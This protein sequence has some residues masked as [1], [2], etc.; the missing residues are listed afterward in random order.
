[1]NKKTKTAALSTLGCRVNQYESDAIADG[2]TGRGF[3]IVPFGTPADVTIL[4]T[5]TV[6]GESDRKSRQLIR[7]AVAA[8]PGCPVIVT[9][10]Y[11]ETGKDDVLRIDGVTYIKGNAKKS[12]IPGIAERLVSEALSFIDTD[13]VSRAAETIVDVEDI[14]ASTYDRMTLTRASRARS[15]MKIEDGCDNRCAY[16][17]IPAARGHVRS[18]ERGDAVNEAKVL[19]SDGCREII[20]TGIE[21][22]SYGRDAG[23][24]REEYMGASLAS[25]IEDIAAVGFERISMGSLEP[26]VMSDKFVRRIAAIPSLLPHFHLSVQSGSS[27]VLARMRRRYNAAM[28]D[29]CITRL[30]EAIPNVFLS[31]D[32]IT[33]FPGETEAEFAETVDF[34]RRTRFLHLHI[35]PYSERRGT[36][37]A[38]MRDQIPVNLRNERLR[39]LSAQQKKIKAELLREYVNA[40]RTSPVHVLVEEVKNGLVCGHSE[41]FVEVRFPVNTSETD[42]SAADIS[43][44]V[45]NVVGKIAEV[46]LTD[47]DGESCTGRAVSFT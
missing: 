41:H 38:G 36:E 26:T 12:D 23:A 35:F 19:L 45:E 44:T 32:I 18:K 10:C 13:N 47:T 8:S 1:M 3:V 9:G 15:Y 6:T 34:I 17:I 33:G 22:A 46:I 28:L 2:L 40:H 4:N 24:E 43:A 14:S 5:C 37:A 29:E 16:C 30:K 20:L 21:V 25:L 42:T 11:S 39:I 27:T 7:R 31:A